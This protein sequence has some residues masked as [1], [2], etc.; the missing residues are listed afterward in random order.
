MDSLV[1]QFAEELSTQVW[2]A[3][4]GE[5][6]LARIAGLHLD[7]GYGECTECERAPWPCA[8]RELVGFEADEDEGE[9]A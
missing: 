9:E 1:T 5:E 8:T 4:R 7:D 2:R 6:R 3:Q